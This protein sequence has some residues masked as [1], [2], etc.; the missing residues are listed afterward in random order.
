MARSIDE[1]RRETTPNRRA[2]SAAR[3]RR[4]SRRAL[5]LQPNEVNQ[6]VADSTRGFAGGFFLIDPASTPIT[7][8]GS[9]GRL[10]P[11]K[12][13]IRRFSPASSGLAIGRMVNVIGLTSCHDVIRTMESTVG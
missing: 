3:D 6:L 2:S 12:S 1:T 13:T 7:G 4:P 11:P 5:S 10:T 9:L 8:L